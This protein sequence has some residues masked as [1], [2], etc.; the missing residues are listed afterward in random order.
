MQET[1]EQPA[2]KLFT[3]YRLGPV[4]LRNRVIRSAAF[5][6]MGENFGPSQQLK[7]YHVA[8]ARGGVGM[9]TVAYAAVCRS[10]LSFRKQLWLRPEIVPALRDLTDAVHREGAA[11]GIQIGHCGNMT[12]LTTAG[13]IPIGAS[14]GFNLYAYTPVRGMRKSEIVQVAKHFGRA[15]HTAADAGFDSVETHAGHGYLIS[16]FLS[17]YTNHRRDEYG[18]SLDNRMR[19]MRMCLEEVMEAA[20]QR[21]VAVLVK[22]NMYDGFKSGIQLPESI[23][24]AKVIESYKVDGIVLSA[25]FV[26]KAPMA[27]MRGL[28]PLYTMSYYSPLWLRYFIRWCGPYMIKQFPFEECYFLEDAKKFRAELKGPLVYVGGLVSREGIDRALDAGFDMVQMARA[29]VNDPA[30]VNKLREGDASTRSECDHRNYCIARMYSVDMKC[31]K[32]CPDLPRKIRE[33]LAKLP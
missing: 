33:E 15:V 32:H 17:P 22:H 6:S 14:T 26:S 3:P 9:T 7:D 12:H 18:G 1:S 10:G 2:S 19:F 24:I 27:V 5:E 21:N 25:G 11:A 13:Q 29:L 23:E 8:V 31:C 28:I 4:T 20:A 30:F 16:Q